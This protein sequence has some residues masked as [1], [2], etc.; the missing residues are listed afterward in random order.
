[1]NMSREELIER[2]TE[3]K[4]KTIKMHTPNAN[5]NYST[6]YHFFSSREWS[7]KRLKEFIAREE[8]RHNRYLQV[9]TQ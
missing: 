7:N 2:A 1:M 5:T 4:I 6:W 8:E 9:L 3:L